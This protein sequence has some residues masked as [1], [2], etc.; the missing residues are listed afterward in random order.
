L[1]TTDHRIIR[2]CRISGERESGE[3]ASLLTGRVE[4]QEECEGRAIP[5]GALDAADAEFAVMAVHDLL[6]NP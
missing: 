6:A 1:K 4:G 5:A 2:P 3:S